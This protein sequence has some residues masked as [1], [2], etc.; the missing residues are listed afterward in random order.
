MAWQ[1]AKVLTVELYSVCYSIKDYG[2]RDQLQR[3]SVSTMNNVAEGFERRSN[4][5][6]KHFLYISKGSCGEVR[7][8]IWLAEGLKY[9]DKVKAEK[10]TSDAMEISKILSGFIKQL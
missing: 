5:E 9:I 2:F 4:K 6:L 7:S 3:A 8:M 1:K 10:L